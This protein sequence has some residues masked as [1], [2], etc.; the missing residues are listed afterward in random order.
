MFMSSQN[1]YVETVIP[2]YLGTSLG[3][4]LE[5]QETVVPSG[6]FVLH[7]TTPWWVGVRRNERSGRQGWADSHSGYKA[8]ARLLWL[9]PLCPGPTSF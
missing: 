8:W 7:L 9:L 3:G 4:L 2:I 5:N 6:P 1:S